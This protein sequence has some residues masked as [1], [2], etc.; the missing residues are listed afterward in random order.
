MI[1]TVEQ[2]AVR[3]SGLII[4]SIRMIASGRRMIATCLTVLADMGLASTRQWKVADSPSSTWIG[5][6]RLAILEFEEEKFNPP[7]A[8]LA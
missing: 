7:T 2:I 1:T 5:G 4:A 6:V 3:A 8:F